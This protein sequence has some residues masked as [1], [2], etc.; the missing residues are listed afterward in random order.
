TTP[1]SAAMK[2]LDKAGLQPG[3]IDLWEINEAFASVALN[4]INSL[5]I[6]EER[7]NVN[8]GAVAMGH[9][10]GA[11]GARI[12]GALVHELRRRGGGLGCAAICSGGGQGDAIIIRVNGA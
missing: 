6:D 2:A 8:G 11:S 7:V 12:I 5:G 3:D 9:P 10:I 1:A 4:T